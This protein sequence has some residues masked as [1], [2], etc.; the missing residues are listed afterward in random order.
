MQTKVKNIYSGKPD[1]R[2]EL[3]MPNSPFFRSFIM[4]PNF[5]FEDFLEG[6]KCFIRG[7]KGSDKTALLLFLNDHIHQK[8]DAAVSSFMYFK[9]YTNID[10][11]N[12]DI[13]TSKY[14][15]QIEENV[16]FDKNT[17]L[18]EQSFI[19]IWRWLLYSRIIEDNVSNKNSLFYKDN[20][21]SG[22]LSFG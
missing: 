13:V 17:L 4:P 8:N 21:W 22:R 10:R 3:S 16:V 20:I 9:E 7:Y 18:K 5:E 12:M 6:D 19:Y 15:N 1:A 14:R 11:N 2:D